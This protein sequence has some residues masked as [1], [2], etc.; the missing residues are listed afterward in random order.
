[1]SAAQ[2]IRAAK[3]LAFLMVRFIAAATSART[4]AQSS[5]KDDAD[6]IVALEQA[7]NRAI[8]AKGSKALD[9]LLAPTFLAVDTDGSRTG[10]GEFL[11]SI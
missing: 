10:N 5:S 2:K 1:M 8:E 4:L 3:P 9:Q 7:W 6:H 11:A